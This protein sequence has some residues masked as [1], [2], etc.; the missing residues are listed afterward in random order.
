MSTQVIAE[1]EKKK[2]G[3]EPI[4][5]VPYITEYSWWTSKL[6]KRKFVI[7]RIHRDFPDE[8]CSCT[9]QPSH[10]EVLEI[11]KTEPVVRSWQEFVVLHQAGEIIKIINQ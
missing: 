3:I 8:G 6:G 4:N 10:V 2:P 7:V 9:P 11:D 5:Y 1:P